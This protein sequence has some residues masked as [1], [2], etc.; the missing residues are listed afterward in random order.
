[1]AVDWWRD[2]LTGVIL[3]YS[4]LSLMLVCCECL[5]SL[6]CCVQCRAVCKWPKACLEL[7]LLAHRLAA[8]ALISAFIFSV[9]SFG[10][11]W[12]WLRSTFCCNSCSLHN[13]LIF[14]D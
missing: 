1:M 6:R 8:D 11:L 10:V 2:V 9:L 14:R 13:L 4:F 7:W 5:L 3:K 12:D